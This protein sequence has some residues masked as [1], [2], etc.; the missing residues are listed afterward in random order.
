MLS[1]DG[2]KAGEGVRRLARP[3]GNEGGAL[4]VK[5]AQAWPVRGGVLTRA[6]V[7]GA[8]DCVQKSRAP[9]CR[10]WLCPQEGGSPGDNV[11][12]DGSVWILLVRVSSSLGNARSAT[13]GL[14]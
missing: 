12:K 11:W 7:P 8:G 5:V 1:T 13:S 14:L 2:K 9:L 4:R 10:S 3:E 6:E